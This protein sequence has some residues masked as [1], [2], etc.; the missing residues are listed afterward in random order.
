MMEFEVH[1]A[2]ED[3]VLIQGRIEDSDTGVLYE[4]PAY[5]PSAVRKLKLIDDPED[6]PRVVM[7]LLREEKY[8]SQTI[9]GW[10]KPKDIS[11]KGLCLV[12]G[13]RRAS[14][15]GIDQIKESLGAHRSS[16]VQTLG[17]IFTKPKDGQIL[18]SD[19]P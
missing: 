17:Q 7:I 15:Y 5:V 4:G 12:H 19:G 8:H 1:E 16:F 2:I 3:M 14:L 9:M 18:Q 11:Y 10:I 6:R 13:I